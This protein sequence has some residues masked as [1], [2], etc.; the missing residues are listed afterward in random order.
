MYN[1]RKDFCNEG[2]FFNY[3]MHGASRCALHK[4]TYKSRKDQFE[5]IIDNLKHFLPD[6]IN[7]EDLSFVKMINYATLGVKLRPKTAIL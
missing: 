3:F 1:Q 6:T 5:H 2:T 4:Q 7:T